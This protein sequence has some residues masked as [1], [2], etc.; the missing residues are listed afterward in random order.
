MWQVA[1][2]VQELKKLTINNKDVLVAIRANFNKP[3]IFR[4]YCKKLVNV[5]NVL[6]RIT[7]AGVILSFRQHVQECL[8][9]VLERRIPFLYNSIKTVYKNH[10]EEPPKVVKEMVSAA[11]LQCKIDPILVNAL[12][13][14]KND[15]ENEDEHF[16]AGLLV[17][18][19][20][21]SIPKLARNEN[22]VYKSTMDGHAN[23]IHCIATAV[24]QIFG[25]MFA[26]CNKGDIEDNMKEFLALTTLCLLRLG[27][28]TDKE[29]IKN[30]DSVYLLLTYIIEESSFL[31][32]DMLE[33]C[34]PYALIRN[35]FHDVYKL[36]DIL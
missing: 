22:S 36:D 34:F 24:H 3:D 25:A 2:Q 35:S 15:F 26:I 12:K 9:D 21:V 17:L 11:G 30:R 28:E 20:A 16:I 32:I 33:T 19:V 13:N 4:D 29:S 7:I 1:S 6:Q 8:N 23:N 14:L 27:Q 5:E 18:F 10:N 31:T